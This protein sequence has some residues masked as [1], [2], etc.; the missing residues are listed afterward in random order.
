MKNTIAALTCLFAL[1]HSSSA[2][3]R[4]ALK[5]VPANALKALLVQSGGAQLRG[6]SREVEGDRIIYEAK[7]KSGGRT[8]E[9]EVDASGTL[10]KVGTE[11]KVKDLP[12]AVRDRVRKIAGADARIKE[13]E[14][15]MVVTYEVEIEKDGKEIELT[16]SATGKALGEVVEGDENDDN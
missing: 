15:V 14:K 11:I 5:D 1:V 10:L 9:A 13:A 2:D 12:E 6:L 7:W 8:C 3:E 4:V 16:L